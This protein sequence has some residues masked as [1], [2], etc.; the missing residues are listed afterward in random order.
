VLGPQ[1]PLFR[2]NE[3]RAGCSHL[4]TDILLPPFPSCLRFTAALRD[5]RTS[6]DDARAAMH[7]DWREL[8]A[9]LQGE[10]SRMAAH[11]ML[12]RDKV[13]VAQA[14]AASL[15][16]TVLSADDATGDVRLG[17]FQLPSIPEAIMDA[18]KGACIVR[19]VGG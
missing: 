13:T 10:R 6:P 7:P 11:T 12:T 9:R 15:S 19:G 5:P 8:A 14:V 17:V 4:G 3:Y 2:S 16:L 1:S 18:P